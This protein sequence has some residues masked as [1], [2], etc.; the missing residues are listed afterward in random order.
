MATNPIV[1]P[2]PPSQAKTKHWLKC[3]PGST[4]ENYPKDAEQVPVSLV[5]PPICCG[6]NTREIPDRGGDREC[7][8]P[9]GCGS[10]WLP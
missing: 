9:G 2:A 1:P 6:A 7:A 10:V 8:A 4:A 5:E 3:P